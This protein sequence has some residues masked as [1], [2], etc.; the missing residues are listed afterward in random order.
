[1]MNIKMIVTDLDNTLLRSDKSISKYTISIF[2]KCQKKG[3]KVVFAT[4]RSKQAAARFLDMF[5]PDVFIGYGGALAL[6][7]DEVI[8]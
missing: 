3:I 5:M 4:A 2:S 7:G 1:M 8:N 6:S